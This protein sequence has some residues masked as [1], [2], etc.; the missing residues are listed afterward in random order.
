MMNLTVKQIVGGYNRKDNQATAWIYNNYNRYAYQIIKN[1]TDNSQDTWDLVSV[2][3]LKLINNPRRLGTIREIR[4][5]IK[6][7]SINT[8][9]DYL[10]KEGRRKIKPD[11]ME[12]YAGIMAEDPFQTFEP[13]QQFDMLMLMSAKKLSPQCDQVLRL[14]YG[15][16]MTNG[17]VAMEM[18]LSEKTVANLKIMARKQL[19]LEVIK[20]GINLFI[21]IIFML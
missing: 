11:N 3:F 21:T 20:A 7:T 6:L 8:C 10:E 5:F 13:D 17:E 14:C 19:K 1:L 2:V 16:G 18:N 4:D 15:K 9:I 12:K